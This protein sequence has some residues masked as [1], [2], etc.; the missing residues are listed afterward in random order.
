[1]LYPDYQSSNG[2]TVSLYGRLFFK[3]TSASRKGLD[4]YVD[5]ERT[6][7]PDGEGRDRWYSSVCDCEAW[8]YG[9]RP[10]RHIFAA[11]E[12]LAEWGHVDQSIREEWIDRLMFLL[13]M[14]HSFTE[15]LQSESMQSLRALIPKPRVAR[16]YVLDMRKRKYETPTADSKRT[17]RRLPARVHRDIA[18]SVNQQGA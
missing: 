6:N 9:E 16:E 7:Y 13:N 1:M 4:H 14:G 18:G 2:H 12:A 11:F 10:C 8:K 3:M 5:L 17:K 15:A